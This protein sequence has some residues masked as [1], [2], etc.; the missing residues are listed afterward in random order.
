MSSIPLCRFILHVAFL[1]AYHLDLSCHFGPILVAALRSFRKEIEYLCHL[2]QIPDSRPLFTAHLYDS[3][4]LESSPHARG[5]PAVEL[6]GRDGG[7]IIPACAGNTLSAG[8]VPIGRRDHPRMRGEHDLVTDLLALSA[9][10]SPHARGTRHD[11]AAADHDS[12]I[13]PACAGNTRAAG[14]QGPR[15]RDH[16]HMRGEHRQLGAL[17]RQ[18]GGSSPH[19]RGPLREPPRRHVGVG[20]IPACAGS[21][22][23]PC[24]PA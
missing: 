13:I 24:P 2:L 10:S 3:L 21:T 19:A 7:G 9:G 6:L 20:I 12:G 8:S 23:A 16:P 14:G 11:A 17:A 5:A 15:A 18:R 4:I 1:V 22:R